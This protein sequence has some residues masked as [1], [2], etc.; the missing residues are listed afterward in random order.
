MDPEESIQQITGWSLWWTA[1]VCFL[2]V[3]TEYLH[4]TDM[5]CTSQRWKRGRGGGVDSKK[6]EGEADRT[7]E[8]CQLRLPVRH[9]KVNKWLIYLWIF[10]MTLKLRRLT[11]VFTRWSHYFFLQ[12]NAWWRAA[13]LSLVIFQLRPRHR[14]GLP[15]SS[16][17][18]PRPLSLESLF[19]WA[20]QALN[21]STGMPFVY[22]VSYCIVHAHRFS[23]SSRTWQRTHCLCNRR[24]MLVSMRIS[25]RPGC[26]SHIHTTGVAHPHQRCYTRYQI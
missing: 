4:N 1:T 2:R 11:L 9:K 16:R 8:C 23:V 12:A 14:L 25:H 10:H 5:K 19:I 6:T 15:Y 7:T 20:N 26:D 24:S 18:T 17:A 21:Q 3:G 13:V 22:D